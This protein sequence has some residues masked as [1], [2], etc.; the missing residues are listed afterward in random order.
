MFNDV[1]GANRFLMCT[2]LNDLL[3]KIFQPYRLFRG[4]TP[5]HL[6]GS[7][8]RPK[9]FRGTQATVVARGISTDSVCLRPALRAV[10]TTR[11]GRIAPHGRAVK[12]QLL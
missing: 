11:I 1:Q 2:A 7:T 4:D 6:R 12:W 3:S 10:G 5:F 9:V 8:A